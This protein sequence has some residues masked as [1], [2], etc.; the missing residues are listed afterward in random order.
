MRVSRNEIDADLHRGFRRPPVCVWVVV[1]V[2]GLVNEPPPLCFVGDG[3]GRRGL[4]QYNIK[5][6]QSTMN[7]SMNS[8]H[9][10]LQLQVGTQIQGDL[11]MCWIGWPAATRAHTTHAHTKAHERTCR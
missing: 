2:G 7:Q 9:L 10:A 3:W 5:L 8:R 1:R 6:L 4:I 11:C